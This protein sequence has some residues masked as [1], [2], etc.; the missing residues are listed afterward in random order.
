MS[1]IIGHPVFRKDGP[2]KVT[3][4]A[5]YT[6]DTPASGALHAVVVVSTVPAGEIAAIDTDAAENIA[7]VVKIFTHQNLPKMAPLKTLPTKL[8]HVPMQSPR[9]EYEGQPVAIVVAESLQ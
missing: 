7:G 9:V 1:T 8:K 6:A 5:R 3:G 4:A 2:V